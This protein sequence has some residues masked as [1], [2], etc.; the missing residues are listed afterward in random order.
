M[1]LKSLNFVS[2]VFHSYG[3]AEIKKVDT[4]TVPFDFVCF[5]K[6]I[7]PDFIKNF[8]AELNSFV[9]NLLA[10][11]STG[12]SIFSILFCFHKFFSKKIYY[13][14]YST[15]FKTSIRSKNLALIKT[16]DPTVDINL[17]LEY[18]S[19][20][21]LGLRSIQQIRFSKIFKIFIIYL[22]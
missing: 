13:L 15:S 5:E 20:S 21:E 9:Q 11:Q 6:M 8:D 16:T 14:E 7:S 4:K 3:T 2:V 22:N 1:F 12:K 19:P 10:E 18:Y 17:S